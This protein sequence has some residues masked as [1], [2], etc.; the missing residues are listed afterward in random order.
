MK[1]DT[2]NISGARAPFPERTPGP[3][4]V[5][6]KIPRR[7][8]FM[9]RLYHKSVCLINSETPFASNYILNVINSLKYKK[10]FFNLFINSLTKQ[11]L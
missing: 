1:P 5:S 3:L 11:K 10:P 7:H 6:T 4:H 9:P 8:H 2:C